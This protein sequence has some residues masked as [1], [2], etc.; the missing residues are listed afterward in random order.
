[1]V[2]LLRKG[3]KFAWDDQCEEIFKQFKDFLTSP[4][5]IQKPRPDHPILVYLVLGLI[6]PKFKRGGEL[7]F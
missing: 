3:K 6:V 2:Q 1:M 7:T 4:I 5:I